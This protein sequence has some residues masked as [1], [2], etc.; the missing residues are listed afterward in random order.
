[1]A[2]YHAIINDEINIPIFFW[3]AQYIYSTNVLRLATDNLSM[4]CN[5]LSNLKT[6]SIRTE[7]DEE[8]AYF[9]QYDGYSSISYLGNNYSEQIGGFGHEL[10]VT[11][12]KLDLIEAVERLD[13]Q[14]NPVID[15]ESMTLE[16]YKN[17]KIEQ[18]SK[19]GE[20]LIFKGTDVILGDGSVKN[21]TYNLEDQS[22]LLNALFIIGQLDDLTITLP[23][24]SHGEP[25]E[26]YGALDIIRVYLALQTYSTTM[27][28]LV[29]MK[30]N[31]VRS[32]ETKEE[33][34]AITFESDLPEVWIERAQ[35]VLEPAQLLVDAIRQKYFPEEEESN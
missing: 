17:Y 31:W 5:A 14:V 9:T 7:V 32:C 33:V 25:C 30:N 24:H 29:N 23:Y 1:M 4:V 22:N 19:A 26:L 3:D 6:I 8:V 18:F 20:N 28:T 35:S 34:S 13:H 11:L 12:T 15:I 27:Q 21:F 10:Q 2:Q 16:E